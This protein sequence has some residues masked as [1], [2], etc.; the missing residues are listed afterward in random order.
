MNRL[1]ATRAADTF[2][3]NSGVFSFQSD[4]P[5]VTSAQTTGGPV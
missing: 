3:G 1:V 4:I 5:V 2:T